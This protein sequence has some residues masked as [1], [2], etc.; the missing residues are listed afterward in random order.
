MP[1]TVILLVIAFVGQIFHEQAIQTLVG[2]RD[3]RAA[4]AAAGAISNQLNFHG[5]EIQSLALRAAGGERVQSLLSQANLPAEDL[6]GLAIIAP[7]GTLLAATP[8]AEV[9]EKYLALAGW[10]EEP[11]AQATG[12]DPWFMPL[13]QANGAGPS[14]L[15]VAARGGDGLTAVG[16]VKP[17]EIARRALA[18]V[19]LAD[20][21][22]YAFI[23]DN[24]NQVIFQMGQPPAIETES[25]P[26]PV[27][28]R[29]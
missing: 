28:P 8:N 1:L 25:P 6:E 9:W 13:F 24:Q 23:V 29:P 11:R 19:L 16:A 4:R 22:T 26:H 10:P 17:V 27:S 3:E 5:A 18:E 15:L 14:I 20:E 12:P 2:Q 21:E 7:D